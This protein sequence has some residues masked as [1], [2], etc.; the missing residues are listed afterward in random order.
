MVYKSDLFHLRLN[1]QA[2]GFIMCKINASCRTKIK[3]KDAQLHKYLQSSPTI[4]SEK[5]MQRELF[6]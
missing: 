3:S 5:L 2:K 1:S 6:Q 4:R